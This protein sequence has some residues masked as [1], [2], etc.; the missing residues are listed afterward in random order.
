MISV[1]KLLNLDDSGACSSCEVENSEFEMEIGAFLFG[2]C[3]K[4]IRMLRN[5]LDFIEEEE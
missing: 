3:N 5:D 1:S 4:C 2:I